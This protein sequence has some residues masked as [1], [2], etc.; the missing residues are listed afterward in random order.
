MKTF[1]LRVL[2]GFHDRIH[3]VKR[4]KKSTFEETDESRV[5]KLIDLGYVGLLSVSPNII[6]K[7]TIGKDRLLDKV[8]SGELKLG[9]LVEEKAPKQVR[10]T[11]LLAGALT[12]TA[13]DLAKA[14]K[15]KK[16]RNRKPKDSG[17]QST[18]SQPEQ[19]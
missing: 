12:D 5:K 8:N 14:N 16:K 7:E 19:E 10:A 11:E 3:D 2:K 18:S 15:P 9:E 17:T 6:T 13:L 4:E 1:T